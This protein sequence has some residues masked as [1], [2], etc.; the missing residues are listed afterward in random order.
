ME[1]PAATGIRNTY[2]EEFLDGL[3]DSVGG[4]RVED[5]QWLMDCLV[6]ENWHYTVSLRQ[7]AWWSE[8]LGSQTMGPADVFGI[9]LADAL[10]ITFDLAV[11]ERILDLTDN[12]LLKWVKTL[13]AAR[14]SVAKPS[15]AEHFRYPLQ[16]YSCDTC[17]TL[18]VEVRQI[19]C[20]H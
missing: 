16:G 6:D 5:V 9:K 13:T 2:L 20:A 3:P 10:A 11:V 1:E 15:Q 18:Q 19:E 4:L 14:A 17:S 7:V 12:E 8:R